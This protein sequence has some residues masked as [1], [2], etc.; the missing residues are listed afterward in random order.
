L[1]KVVVIY[2]D[3]GEGHWAAATALAEVIRLQN[4]AWRVELVNV[5]EMLQPADPAV[6]LLGVRT[7]YIYNWLVARDLIIATRQLL[8]IVHFIFRLLHP[9]M[10]FVLRRY[11]RTL[12]PDLVVSV[13]PHR[14]RALFESLRKENPRIP[15]VTILTD[16]ADYPPRFWIER[17]EQHFIC[18][19]ATA[20][21]QAEQTAPLAEGIWS[22][23]GMIVHPK[24]YERSSIDRAQ[25][26]RKLGLDPDLPTGL[27]LFGGYGSRVMLEIA[28]RIAEATPRLQVIFLCGRNLALFRKLKSLSFTYHAHVQGFTENVTYFMRLSDFLIGKPGPGGISEALA[29]RLPIIVNET[30]RTMVHERFNVKWIEEQG[31]GT[32][33]RR[34][35]DLPRA[36]E[37]LLEPANYSAMQQKIEAL[38]NRAVFEIPPILEQILEVSQG[39]VVAERDEQPMPR[40]ACAG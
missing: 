35:R 33:I 36:I 11:W 38:N 28:Q 37:Q 15:F 7:N 4:K 12:K 13:V 3:A 31:V 20:V 40:N 18:G 1:K 39:S 5:D 32:A 22:V 26:R 19:T 8:P 30:W 23:S 10:V 14:N 34:I 9:A 17:Q 16:L 21:H 6:C 27:L 25:E 24:F 2:I 29:M